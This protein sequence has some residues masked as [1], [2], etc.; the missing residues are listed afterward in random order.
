MPE[1]YLIHLLGHDGP[2][3]LSHYLKKKMFYFYCF[4]IC[5]YNFRF[6]HSL[7][8]YSFISCE[9]FNLLEVEMILTEKGLS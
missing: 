9:S 5:L 2:K 1:R 8:A 3:S 4:L 7:N 6:V